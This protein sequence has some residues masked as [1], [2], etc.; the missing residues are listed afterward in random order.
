[1]ENY[2][3]TPNYYNQ[4]SRLHPCAKE[5]SKISASNSSHVYY[6]NLYHVIYHFKAHFI[7]FS[8]MPKYLSYNFRLLR[9]IKLKE[10]WWEIKSHKMQKNRTN[11]EY[12]EFCAKNFA[13]IFNNVDVR[14]L[15]HVISF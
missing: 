12:L 1:M 13:S 2:I 4:F 10:L 11:L 9:S 6:R 8:K 15:Y 14:I 5:V 3:S 7:G